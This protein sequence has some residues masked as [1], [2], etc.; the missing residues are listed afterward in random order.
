MILKLLSEKTHH[1]FPS[2]NQVI[3]K[4]FLNGMEKNKKPL[5]P[6]HWQ[7]VKVREYVVSVKGEKPKKI[8]PIKTNEFSVP[9]V[10]IKAFEK[11]VI[12][13]YTDGV[14]CVL[15]DEGDFLMVWDGS[16]SSYVGKAIKG[17]L[18][19]TLVKLNFPNLDNNY[20]FYFLQSKFIEINT[21]AKGVGIPHV[22]PNILWNYKLPIPPLP[23]QQLIVSKIEELLSDLENGK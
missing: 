21:R 5:I 1:L 23:E 4:N 22:D 2:D 10:N 15:C 14:G 19:S 18:G 9:Y 7:I 20:A 13:E 16:R 6:T 17:A 12:D 8:S 3:I 11:N